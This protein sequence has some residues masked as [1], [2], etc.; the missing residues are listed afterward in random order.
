MGLL[1]G[2]PLGVVNGINRSAFRLGCGGT[3]LFCGRLLGTAVG[4][5]RYVPSWVWWSLVMCL[6]LP[7]FVSTNGSLVCFSDRFSWALRTVWLKWLSVMWRLSYHLV[8]SVYVSAWRWSVPFEVVYYPW[9]VVC[10]LSFFGIRWVLYLF[11]II[12]KLA[13]L[14]WDSAV[15]VAY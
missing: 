4:I 7:V 8:E 12:L 10:G 11:S 15:R 9:G 2:G 14:S 5:I 3:V 1:C 6:S 13:V